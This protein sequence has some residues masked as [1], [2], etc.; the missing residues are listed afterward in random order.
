MTDVPQDLIVNA[1]RNCADAAESVRH[2]GAQMNALL[3]QIFD[4]VDFVLWFIKQT[5]IKR[6]GENENVSSSGSH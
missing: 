2:L 6:K 1:V 3:R 4:E 5:E